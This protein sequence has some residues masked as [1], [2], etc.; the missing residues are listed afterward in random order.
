MSRPADQTGGDQ[1]DGGHGWADMAADSSSPRTTGSEPVPHPGPATALMGSGRWPD[2]PVLEVAVHVEAAAVRVVVRGELDVATRPQ[3][4]AATDTLRYATGT[5]VVLDLSGLTFVDVVGLGALVTLWRRAH[6]RGSSL[7]I[8]HAQP[9]VRRLLDLASRLSLVP[10]A[11]TAAAAAPAVPQL[12]LRAATDQPG[13]PTH[14]EEAVWSRQR[15]CPPSPM[16]SPSRITLPTQTAPPSRTNPP[17]RTPDS[18]IALPPQTTPPLRT[19]GNE[20]RARVRTARWT[21]TSVVSQTP[22]G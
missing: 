9:S 2:F 21:S 17:P 16:T 14:R 19:A 10:A 18:R 12:R 7:S 1:T 4:M 8:R 22:A 20:S 3:L 5:R 15:P 11:F 13:A 6:D